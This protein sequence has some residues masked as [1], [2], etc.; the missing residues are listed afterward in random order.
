MARNVPRGPEQKV[1]AASRVA[2]AS[3]PQGEMMIDEEH[4]ELSSSVS[5]VKSL[6][7]L[8]GENL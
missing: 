4:D 7:D 8:V 2:S 6:A 3:K 5:D 1:L